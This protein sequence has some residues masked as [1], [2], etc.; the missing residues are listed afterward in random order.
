V[1]CFFDNVIIEA[2]VQ[3]VEENQES[4]RRLHA[5]LKPAVAMRNSFS[6][7]THLLREPLGPLLLGLEVPLRFIA[8]RYRNDWLTSTWFKKRLKRLKTT[9]AVPSTVASRQTEFAVGVGGKSERKNSLTG[10][11]AFTENGLILMRRIMS[12]QRESNPHFNLRPSVAR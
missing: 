12:G 1:E 9:Q 3:F 2:T 8:P 5:G 11:R 7:I 4:V 6:G 10:P